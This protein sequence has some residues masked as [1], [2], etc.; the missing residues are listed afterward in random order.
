P[1]LYSYRQSTQRDSARSSA[2][3]FST[4][5]GRAFGLGGLPAAAE[6]VPLF[7]L[8]LADVLSMMAIAFAFSNASPVL[9]TQGG[10]FVFPL[11]LQM[12]TV[13]T[14][15]ARGV[16]VQKYGTTSE[17]CLRRRTAGAAGTEP[18]LCSKASISAMEI[19]QRG[20]SP[21]G[22]KAMLTAF[23]SPF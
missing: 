17:D 15:S 10:A 12:P 19:R 3:M 22:F 5:T 14:Q 21:A 1:A 2:G 23:S 16:L 6:S 11:S 13:I 8:Q 18:R 20:R 4:R 9:T 7:D